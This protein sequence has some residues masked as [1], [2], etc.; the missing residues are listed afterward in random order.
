MTDSE[1]KKIKEI[2]ELLSKHGINS[3]ELAQIKLKKMIKMEG[4]Q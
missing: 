2:I 1:I 3:K 4:Q